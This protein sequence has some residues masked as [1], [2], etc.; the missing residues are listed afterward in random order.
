MP[1]IYGKI[2]AYKEI[3]EKI[4]N[5][6]IKKQNEPVPYGTDSFCKLK[7][8]KKGKMMTSTLLRVL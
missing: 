2:I 4:P 8:Y 1:L 5:N 3:A 6:Y 7:N